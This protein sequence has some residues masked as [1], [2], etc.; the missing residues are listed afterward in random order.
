MKKFLVS[1]LFLG[2]SGL[3]LGQGAS[4]KVLADKIIGVVGNKIVLQSDIT[5]Q[6]E[7]AKR[8]G[9]ELPPNA[10]CMLLEQ[11]MA[12]KA[13]VLQAEKDSLPVSDEEVEAEL[14]LRVRNFV[15]YYNGKENLEQ[16]AG[17]TV[18]QIK[19]DFRP[20]IRENKLANAM[21]SKILENV[22]ITP[23]EVKE[24]F[25][26]TSS[27]SAK[28]NYYETKLEI[29]QIVIYPK[30]SRD[31]EKY[32]QDELAEYKRQVE[33]GT[34]SFEKLAKLYSDDP[35]TKDNGGRFEFNKNDKNVDQTFLNTSF[36]LKEGQ[37]SRVIKSKF[38]YHLIQVIS[39][40][41]DDIVVR[42][43]LKIPKVTDTEI[44]EA[45]SKLDSIRAKLVTGIMGFGE[46]VDRYSEDDN[47]KFTAGAIT[48]PNGGSSVT[49]DQLD[50]DLV[51]MLDKLKIGEYSQPVPFT[52]D[53]GKQ[54]VRIL[55]LQNKT[56]PHAE[57]LKDDYNEIAQR[58]LEEKKNG[59]MD[60]WFQSKMPTYYI[61]VDKEYHDCEQVSKWIVNSTAKKK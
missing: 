10:S 52:D 13:L 18:Y 5:N 22:K 38:G 3:V 41:G 42:H 19:E 36:A 57:N 29:K 59:V 21:H 56:Q 47:S 54:G 31:L 20:Q 28:R 24:Y 14:D 27:D 61:T 23:T 15:N 1:T 16:I 55:Y 53:R 11:M 37:I 60:K 25:E 44:K 43:I 58:A 39:R 34:T 45:T 32:A 50:K 26:R 17:R 49:I 7:D 6:I 51:T 2:L 33:T 35:G 8:Q 9:Q 4:K 48:G 40:N 30:A 46:A 12:Q